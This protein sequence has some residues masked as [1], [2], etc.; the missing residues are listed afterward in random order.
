MSKRAFNVSGPVPFWD[1]LPRFLGDPGAHWSWWAVDEGWGGPP[2]PTHPQ[3][4]PN[5]VLLSCPRMGQRVP[6]LPLPTP[7]PTLHGIYQF[8][9]LGQNQASNT[10]L[11]WVLRMPGPK[12]V[13]EDPDLNKIVMTSMTHVELFCVPR[14]LY[15]LSPSSERTK[16]DAA[17]TTTFQ[18]KDPSWLS[19]RKVQPHQC[20]GHAPWPGPDWL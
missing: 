8:L 6:P 9:V 2:P 10:E 1:A 16:R 20:C 15:P 3:Y 18:M 14:T 17:F 5:H 7:V 11:I 13:L 19:T 12:T 4:R